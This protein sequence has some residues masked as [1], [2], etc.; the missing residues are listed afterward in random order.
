[1]SLE[2]DTDRRLRAWIS[3]G[4]DSAPERFVWAALDEIERVPQRS[5]WRTAVDSLL[6]HGLG[7]W[8]SPVA[9]LVSAAAVVVVALA[10]ATVAGP[11]V[12]V[13]PGTR[14]FEVADLPAIV[15]WQDTKPATWMLD[16]LV[17][18]TTEVRRIPIRS[19]AGSQIDTLP[20]PPGLLG[21][22]YTN[23]SGP[24]SAFMSWAI[25]F[26]RDLDAEAALPF[27]QHELEAQEAWGLGPG[28]AVPLGDEGHLFEG[29][30]TA[31]VGQPTGVDPHPAA[32][33]LWR[34][35]NLL[36]ALGGWF[37][38]DSGEL[39]AVAEGMDHRAAQVAG[40]EP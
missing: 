22:R 13:A 33:Y 12:G 16:N 35:G 32:I 4:A 29:E 40:R 5:S 34:D 36:L 15:V 20:D 1:M 9:G 39:Q 27:Y 23:F 17:S 26:E 2:R 3:E 18:N 11:R 6:G 14:H 10:I 28:E 31:L 19:M 38:F 8:L 30:T 37:A 7:R 25:V 21:A 24:D